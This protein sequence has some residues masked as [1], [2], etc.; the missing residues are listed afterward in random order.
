LKLNAAIPKGKKPPPYWRKCIKQLHR[1]YGGVCAYLSVYLELPPGS[2]TV[3]HYVAK[4]KLAGKAYKWSNY[5]LASATMNSRKRDYDTVLDPFGL[6]NETFHLDLVSGRMYP[7]PSLAPAAQAKAKATIDRLKLDKPCREMRA[8]RFD[9]Y[10]KL[11]A[12]GPN[13]AAVQ[14]LKKYSPFIWY[15]ANRQGLL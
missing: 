8:R 14:Q 12:G 3:D 6:K 2:V 10:L 4:S 5:R 13:S 11:I 1:N 7:N 15:E 9:D